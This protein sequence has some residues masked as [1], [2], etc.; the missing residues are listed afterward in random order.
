MP[1]FKSTYHSRIY[2]DF[3]SIDAKAY[4]EI[5]RYYERF[6][7]QILNLPS[8][9]EYHDMLVIYVNALFEIGAYRK[10]LLLVDHVIEISVKTDLTI[11]RGED[12]FRMSLFRKSASL[13]N[14]HEFRKCEVILRQLVK[15]DPFD[16]IT[17]RFYRKCL[18]HSRPVMVNKYRAT[19]VFLFLFSAIVIGIEVLFIRPFYD[20]YTPLVEASRNFL[21]LSACGIWVLGWSYNRWIAHRQ[22]KE[23]LA[24]AKRQVFEKENDAFNAT[25]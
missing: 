5:V 10:H 11:F 17:V 13:F 6:E 25:N 16:K 18:R 23:I 14:T 8:T 15:I 3:K 2:M 21:F 9:D 7:D 12:L 20:N 1:F 24:K 4:R 19:T 22:A